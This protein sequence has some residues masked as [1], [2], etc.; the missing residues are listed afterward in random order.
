VW[1]FCLGRLSTS[2]EGWAVSETAL[3]NGCC[4]GKTQDKKQFKGEKVFF[5][6]P[7]WGVFYHERKGI[8]GYKQEEAGYAVSN[9]RDQKLGLAVG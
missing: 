4:C 3:V 8:H 7:A 5:G 9:V 6:I 2:G 1:G